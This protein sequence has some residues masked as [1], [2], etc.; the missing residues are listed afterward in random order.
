VECEFLPPLYVASTDDID[1]I[2]AEL[3]EK[4]NAAAPDSS[5]AMLTK[6]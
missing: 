2:A 6:P 1:T 5:G 4:M 3:T